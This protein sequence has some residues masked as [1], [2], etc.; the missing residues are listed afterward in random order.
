MAGAELVQ[1]ADDRGEE[2]AAGGCGEAAVEDREA[3]AGA[4]ALPGAVERLRTHRGGDH[5]VAEAEEDGVEVAVELDRRGVG[6]DQLDVGGA[7][8]GDELARLGQHPRREVDPGDRTPRPDRVEQVGKVAAAADPHLEHVVA[9]TQ[10]HRP[11]ALRRSSGLIRK[12]GASDP[13]ERRDAVVL[14]RDRALIQL[15]RPPHVGTV[16][17]R[18]ICVNQAPPAVDLR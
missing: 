12:S 17:P 5:R 6:L 7:A 10:R 18:S 14:H 4:Q 16:P 9:G 13:V 3:A 15:R 2:R 1:Q 8:P 11:T